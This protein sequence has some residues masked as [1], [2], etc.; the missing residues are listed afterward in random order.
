M[1]IHFSLKGEFERAR[2]PYEGLAALNRLVQ[3]LAGEPGALAELL[4]RPRLPRL[5]FR[6]AS[7]SESLTEALVRMPALV[8]LLGYDAMRDVER[9]LEE[10]P[11]PEEGPDALRRWQKEVLLL[12]QAREVVLGE[13]LAWSWRI[14]TEL[15]DRVCRSVL[16]RGLRGGGGPR[17]TWN[18]GICTRAWASWPWAARASARF[19][20][21]PTWT[22]CS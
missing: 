2:D 1:R 16:E 13:P 21:A 17:G 10:P 18:L 6:L 3:A 9:R 8:C 20:P 12:A 15:A 11:K 19:T 22:W 4:E 5:L 14:H 7:Q